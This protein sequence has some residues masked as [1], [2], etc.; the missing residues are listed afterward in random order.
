VVAD[1]CGVDEGGCADV[2]FAGELD[3]GSIAALNVV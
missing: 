1:V 2:T 3:E